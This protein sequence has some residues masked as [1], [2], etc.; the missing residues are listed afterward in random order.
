MKKVDCTGN[1]GPMHEVEEYVTGYIRVDSSI[2]DFR[3]QFTKA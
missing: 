2:E 1:R 3:D